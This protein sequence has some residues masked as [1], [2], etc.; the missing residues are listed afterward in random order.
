L[1]RK[2]KMNGI[3]L[4][5]LV[6]IIS[7]VRADF[8]INDLDDCVYDNVND[9]LRMKKECRKFWKRGECSPSD[10]KEVARD[11]KIQWGFSSD[12]QAWCYLSENVYLRYIPDICKTVPGGIMRR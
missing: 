10:V 5:I 11:L 9:C 6:A 3:K 7:C 4:C 2:L 12:A 1:E 8:D